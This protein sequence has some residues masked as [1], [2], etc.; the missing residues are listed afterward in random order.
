M[1]ML[2]T[3]YSAISMFKSYNI[4]VVRETLYHQSL[5]DPEG[6]EMSRLMLCGLQLKGN[7]LGKA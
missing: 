3:I 5:M 4:I 1:L 7:K 2:T 6:L